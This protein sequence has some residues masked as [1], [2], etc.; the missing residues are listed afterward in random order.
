M[1]PLARHNIQLLGAFNFCNDFRIFAPIV[2]V[3]FAQVTGSFALATLLFSIAKVT[4][5]AFEVPTG[6]F[7]DVVGRRTTLVLGQIASF[8]CVAC[9]AFG[10]SFALLALGAVLGGVAFAFFSGNNEALLFDTLK[11]EGEQGGYAE[12]QGRLSALFQLALSISAIVAMVALGWLS[13]R[14][15]FILSLAPQALGVVFALLLVEPP[16]SSS[17]P[18]NVLA[19]LSAAVDGFRRDARLR[20]V[21]LAAM[22]GYALGEAKHMFHPAFFATLWPAWA[23]GL[24]G[25]LVHGLSALGFRF[26]GATIGRLGELRVLIGGTGASLI[27]GAGAAAIPTLAS[28]ALISLSSLFFGPGMVAQGSLMQKSFSDTQRATMASLVS[29]GGNI[30]FAIAVFAIGA[31]ADRIGPRFALLTAEFLSIPVAVL[32][33]RLYRATRAPDATR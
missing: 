12:W 21:S 5:S 10:N 6:L 18:S 19:H 26:A 2:V 32:Y 16:R 13:L 9:Y 28:P 25:A 11:G 27:L 20:Q 15:M 23:L 30:I 1:R 14:M 29:L 8:G 31:L 24:A 33:G 22:L 17:I 7:S 3:Y 4:T